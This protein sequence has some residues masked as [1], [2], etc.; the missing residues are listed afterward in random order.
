MKIFFASA[1]H[2]RKKI[3][4]ETKLSHSSLLYLR[5]LQTSLS[6]NK[7]NSNID[8]VQLYNFP[9]GWISNNLIQLHIQVR[10]FYYCSNQKQADSTTDSSRNL[11]LFPLLWL[12]S[13]LGLGLMLCSNRSLA[14]SSY[15]SLHANTRGSY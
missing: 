8:S 3:L 6:N 10:S 5:T 15:I 11:H 1:C 2:L 7:Y 4:S 13:G 12:G 14:R 9:I